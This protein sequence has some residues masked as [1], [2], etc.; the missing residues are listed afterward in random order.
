MLLVPAACAL[1]PTVYP[2]PL[3][4]LTGPPSTEPWAPQGPSSCLPFWSHFLWSVWDQL[5][6]MDVGARAG[7][8]IPVPLLGGHNE[9]RAVAL[10]SH[11]KVTGMFTRG[12]HSHWCLLGQGGVFPG[13]GTRHEYLWGAPCSSRMGHCLGKGSS[14]PLSCLPPGSCGIWSQGLVLAPVRGCSRP[15]PECPHNRLARGGVS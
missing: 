3:L 15:I 5:H 6:S 8:T 10:P 12:Q 2:A 11:P 13:A 1:F 7:I 14:Q 9:R 4:S